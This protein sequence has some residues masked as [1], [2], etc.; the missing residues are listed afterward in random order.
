MLVAGSS[1][2]H[3]LM[4]QISVMG[5]KVRARDRIAVLAALI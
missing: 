4:N 1:T 3:F 5:T 2:H